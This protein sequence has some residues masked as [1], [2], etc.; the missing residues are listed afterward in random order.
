MAKRSHINMETKL[1]SALLALGHIPYEDSKLM[2]AT[3]ICSL[4]H[5]DHFPLRV[6]DGGED[7]PWNLLP[8]LIGDHRAKTAKIDQ[9][10]LG[11]QR[12]IRAREQEH[13]AVL[14]AKIA[15]QIAMQK[16]T[17]PKPK[18]PSRPF[19]KGRGFAARNENRT[20]L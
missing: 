16:V 1:A 10:Q 9:P 15:P 12:R 7:V 5:F 14:Q 20:K 3:Q 2:T 18:M 13:Q 8:R 11:K 4:Y 19:P 6:A 17:W